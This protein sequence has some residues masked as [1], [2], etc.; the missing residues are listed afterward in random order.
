M[1]KDLRIRNSCRSTP[2]PPNCKAYVFRCNALDDV[3]IKVIIAPNYII[4]YQRLKDWMYENDLSDF[5]WFKIAEDDFEIAWS[6]NI[7]PVSK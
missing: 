5:F 3:I 4:A 1:Y 2:V 6:D 7:L